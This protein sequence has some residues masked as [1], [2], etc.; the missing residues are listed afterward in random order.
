MQT[1]SMLDSGQEMRRIQSEME[2]LFADL[3][4][5]WRWSLAG[6][7]PPVNLSRD[8]TSVTVEAQC[9]GVDRA[10]L[11]ITVVGDALTIRGERK[12]EP[13]IPSDAY[14]RRERPLGAFTRVL[15]VGDRFDP[16]RTQATYVNGILRVQLAR[17]PETMPKKIEIKG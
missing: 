4:P 9:A 6:E 15:S 12:P 17:A 11:D 10:T 5:A 7:Y 13:D 1:R 3:A 16:E 2:R 8:E 14:H